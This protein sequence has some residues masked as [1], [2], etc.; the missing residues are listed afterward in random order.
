MKQWEAPKTKLN[1]N[2]GRS[3]NDA[4]EGSESETDVKERGSFN[5]TTES[6]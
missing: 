1:F 6:I 2:E 4:M 5:V 3:G